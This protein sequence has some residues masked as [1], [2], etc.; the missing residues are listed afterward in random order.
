[1]ILEFLLPQPGPQRQLRNFPAVVVHLMGWA[2]VAWVVHAVLMARSDPLVATIVFFTLIMVV[3]F[4]SVGATSR[5]DPDQ[6]SALDWSLATSSLLVGLYFAGTADSFIYRINLLDPLSRIEVLAGSLVVG[7]ALEVTRRTVGP[8]LVL[9]CL[10]LILYNVFGHHLA[11][12]FNHGV[13]SYSDWLDLTVFTTDGLFGA[14]LRV[15]TSYV[16]ALIFF[17]LLF[18]R[19]RGGE[20]F[21]DLAAMVAG[22]GKGGLAKVSVIASGLF[23]TVSGSP[24][25]DVVT[26]GSITI[27][28]MMR[29]GY[30]ARLAGAVEV[31]GSTGGGLLPPVMGSA[32]FLMAEITG[33]SYVEIVVA[34]AV[35]ALLYYGAVYFQ[36]HLRAIKL[37]LPRLS[38]DELPG[39]VGTLRR[40]WPL[41]FPMLAITWLLLSGYTPALAGAGASVILLLVG[42][43]MVGWSSWLRVLAEIPGEA[44][45]RAA[46]VAGACAAAGLIVG[47]LTITGLAAKLSGMVLQFHGDSLLIALAA[48]AV[49]TLLLGMGMPVPSAYLLAAA[50]AGPVLAQ[51]AIGELAGHLFL[52]YFAVMSAMTPPIAVAAFAAASIAGVR[53][54]GI[55][56][57][58]VRLAISAYVIP[59]LF[60]LLPGLLLRTTL[61]DSLVA[62]TISLCVVGLLAMAVEGYAAK[63]LLRWQQACCFIAAGL[64][65]LVL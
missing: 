33:I 43:R 38:P 15:A 55:A 63:P 14:P 44:V 28:E 41:L 11:P 59:F 42:I 53:P 1:M 8:V 62:V 45:R 31:A 29:R 49:I 2:T 60:V 37:D 46:P 64:L 50:V 10:V 56:G 36:L 5:S 27:P 52:L 58:A 39:L 30:P 19:A 12:P 61:Q 51:L 13:I 25:S 26:T 6:P 9:L 32:A 4:L 18:S 24:T 17:G 16:F 20:F 57:G 34:A 48:S 47:G 54:F 23:G 21:C 7:L 65:L 35:P 22:R 40:G 3:V